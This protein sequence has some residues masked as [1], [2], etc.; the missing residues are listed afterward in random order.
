MKLLEDDE[1][2]AQN[3]N[4]PD[5]YINIEET[6]P[7]KTLETNGSIKLDANLSVIKE[8][9]IANIDANQEVAQEKKPIIINEESLSSDS[10]SS[11]SEDDQQIKKTKS[12]KPY[13]EENEKSESPLPKKYSSRKNVPNKKRV[14]RKKIEEEID[15]FQKDSMTFD[16]K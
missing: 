6:L 9:S 14:K 16:R 8:E 3:I 12:S 7:I 13:L 5:I 10:D 2:N 1:E 4:K 11:T 15:G